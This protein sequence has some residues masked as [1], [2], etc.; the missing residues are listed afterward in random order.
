MISCK[1]QGR[2]MIIDLE[3][4]SYILSS[5]QKQ[6]TVFEHQEHQVGLDSVAQLFHVY[7]YVTHRGGKAR[8]ELG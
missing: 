8:L 5:K 1:G 7:E 3:T 2:T 6:F 4:L